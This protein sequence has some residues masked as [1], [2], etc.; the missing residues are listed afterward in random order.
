MI[1][2]T[3]GYTYDPVG[4]LTSIIYPQL[5]ISNQYDA[6]NELTNMTDG[7]G[8]T[9]SPT[10]PPASLRAKPA[11]W[12]SDTISL[13]YNQGHRT[14]LSL[15]QPSGLWSQSYGYDA[16]WRMTNITSPAGAF[17]YAYATPNP[18]PR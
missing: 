10:P 14:S 8:T 3:T 4:N 15:T 2:T 6:I 7:V 18:H 16:E 9:N 12:S 1:G 17:G 11:P 5:T 13:G